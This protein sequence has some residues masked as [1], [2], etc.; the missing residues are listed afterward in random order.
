MVDLVSW[1]TDN[2]EHGSLL[3]CDVIGRVV[4]DIAKEHSA[5][6]SRVKQLMRLLKMKALSYFET[7]GIIQRYSDTSQKT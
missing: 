4:P 1:N 3:G 7:S 6:I 2:S 5:F